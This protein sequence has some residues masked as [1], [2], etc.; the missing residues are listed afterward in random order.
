M[1][2]VDASTIEKHR[3]A[4][5]KAQMS[6]LPRDLSRRGSAL[7]RYSTKLAVIGGGWAKIKPVNDGNGGVG[8]TEY[9]QTD[10]PFK[11][12]LGTWDGSAAVF[13]D[14]ASALLAAR[15]HASDWDHIPKIHDDGLEWIP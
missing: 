13:P 14:A 5:V 11:L 10:M 1:I 8:Y 12:T 6:A 9:A 15:L 3:D 4:A 2:I 7:A